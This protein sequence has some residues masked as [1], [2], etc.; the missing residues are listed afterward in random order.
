MSFFL[1]LAALA[2]VAGALAAVAGFGIGSLLTPFLALRTGISVAVAGVSLAHLCGTALRLLLMRKHVNKKVLLSFGLMSAAGGL[3]GALL[4]NVF[5]SA[6]LTVVFGSLLVVAGLLGITG[7]AG[8]L[9][10]RGPA[11]RV[12]GVVSGLFGGLVG[13]QGGIRSAALLGFELGRDEFVATATATAL[14]VDAARVP[15]YLVTQWD[16]IT[17]I[18]RYILVATAG[19]LAGTVA[20]ITTTRRPWRRF[21]PSRSLRA[22]ESWRSILPGRSGTPARAAS[23][24]K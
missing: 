18:W 19:V 5:R 21:S 2:L 15:V 9:R 13:N 20:L 4:H 11:A 10:I 1:A 17:G 14:M 24:P 6:V 16:E 23:R 7:L 22:T 8:T 3:A 12:A